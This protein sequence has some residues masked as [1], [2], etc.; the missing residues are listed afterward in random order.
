MT[1]APA[2]NT[3][4]CTTSVQITASMP[5]INVYAVTAKPATTMITGRLQPV[6]ALRPSDTPNRIVPTRASCVRR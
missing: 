2:S 6:N 3:R 5:P 4:L 1:A